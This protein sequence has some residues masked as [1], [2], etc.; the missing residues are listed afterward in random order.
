MPSKEYSIKTELLLSATNAI[1]SSFALE[2]NRDIGTRLAVRL[3]LPYI[4]IDGETAISGVLVNTLEHHYP[5]TDAEAKTLLSLCEKLIERKNIRVLD[6][7]VSIC[8]A[9]Y[10][11][12][13]TNQRPGGA[14]HWL[15]AGME[16]ERMVLCGGN[17]HD[18]SWQQSLSTGTCFR[19]L[20]TYCTETSSSLLKGLLGGGEAGVSLLYVRGTEIVAALA[21][22]EI[23]RFI[24]AVKVLEHIVTMAE[25]VALRK[26]DAIVGSSIVA[27]LEKRPNEEDDGV[28]SSLAS[29]SM[30]WNLISLAK[31]ILDRNAERERA[32]ELHLYVASFDV[33]GMHVLMETFTVLK[34]TMDVEG[35]TDISEFDLQEMRLAFANGLMRAFVAENASKKSL[36]NRIARAS[37][38]GLYSSDLAKVSREKQELVVQGMLEF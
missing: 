26:D 11:H 35:R 10:Q 34:A 21:E 7:C 38:D 15:L 30:Y 20:V 24:S 18:G 27:C 28:V 16:L 14:V 37:V 33:R 31:V 36:S 6:G 5:Q 9:R 1:R 13:M 2:S 22:S 29:P 19:K 8:L 12:F 23:A 32:D 4:L 17:K 25:A 3:L